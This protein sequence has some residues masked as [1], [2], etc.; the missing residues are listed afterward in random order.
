MSQD[1]R[2][3]LLEF[4]RK[5]KMGK[6][7][8]F[9]IGGTSIKGAIVDE[10][11]NIENRVEFP[12]PKDPQEVVLS[13]CKAL[14]DFPKL[15]IGV[16]CAGTVDVQEK[17]ITG[18]GGNIENWKGFP[19]GKAFEG[20]GTTLQVVENDANCALKAE[21][22]VGVAKENQSVLMVT[23]GTGIGGAFSLD[24]EKIFH[25]ANY[26]AMEIGHLIL[27]SNGKKCICGQEGCAELYLSARAFHQGM[28]RDGYT[29]TDQYLYL[30]DNIFVEDYMN[31]MADYI[32]SL[33]NIINPSLIVFGGGFVEYSQAFLPEL[34]IRIKERSNQASKT[35]IKKARFKNDAG[36]IGAAFL[37]MEE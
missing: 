5:Y 3:N 18:L 17:R 19:I 14:K 1:Q 15:N 30:E 12:T 10:N 8:G 20:K 31:S 13:I 34:K 7:I 33:Q 27:H 9:D 6:A 35:D 21:L 2:V 28:K 26:A 24:G 25:G 23:I 4:G 32:I 29:D 16:S 36:L 11:G 37:A 22:E